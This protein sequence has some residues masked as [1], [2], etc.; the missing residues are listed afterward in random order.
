MVG[1]PTPIPILF[2]P[3]SSPRKS[4][5]PK[6]KTWWRERSPRLMEKKRRKKGICSQR[7]YNEKPETWDSQ[8][9]RLRVPESPEVGVWL[10]TQGTKTPK[11][12][13]WLGDDWRKKGSNVCRIPSWNGTHWH[14]GRP[15][16]IELCVPKHSKFLIEGSTFDSNTVQISNETSTTGT[17]KVL[18][19]FYRFLS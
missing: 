15:L 6:D 4:N 13:T 18:I 16:G 14:S 11:V 5:E 17:Y 3:S 10:P 7:K 9:G 12:W 19:Q 2:R 8:G 1:Y